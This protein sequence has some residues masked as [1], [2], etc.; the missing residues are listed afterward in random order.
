MPNIWRILLGLTVLAEKLEI[1]ITILEFINLYSLV[2]ISDDL[3]RYLFRSQ[4]KFIVIHDSLSSKKLW[5][6]KYI[7]V[8]GFVEVGMDHLDQYF[9]LRS[10]EALGNLFFL[11]SFNI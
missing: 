11:L 6:N 3:G 9:V 7:F 5:K 4:H 8:Q 1:E 2:E 10:W